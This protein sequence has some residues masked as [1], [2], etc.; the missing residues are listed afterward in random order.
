MVLT[1][2]VDELQK[3]IGVRPFVALP[4]EEIDRYYASVEVHPAERTETEKDC[5]ILPLVAIIAVHYN[6]SWLI[7]TSKNDDTVTTG[8][9]NTLSLCLIGDIIFGGSNDI[10]LDESLKHAATLIVNDYIDTNAGYNLRLAGLLQATPDP[11]VHSY[12]GIVFIARLHQPGVR[13]KHKDTGVRFFGT[14]ELQQNRLQFDSWSRILID[15][16][17]AL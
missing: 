8:A 1:V 10:F 2:R 6:Y 12:L 9:N 13:I 16:I 14:S 17:T 15:H 4:Q 3:I 7:C 11:S 5:S